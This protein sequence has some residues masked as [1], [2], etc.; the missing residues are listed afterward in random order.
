MTDEYG[1]TTNY[2]KSYSNLVLKKT[3][4]TS[5]TTAVDW[6]VTLYDTTVT[7]FGV[8]VP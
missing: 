2:W 4:V 7:A 1:D 5:G 3:T 8:S 6:E